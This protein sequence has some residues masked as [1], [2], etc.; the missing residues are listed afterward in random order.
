M[1]TIHEMIGLRTERSPET[2]ANSFGA[3][4]L[5]CGSNKECFAMSVSHD[6]TLPTTSPLLIDEPPLQVQPRLAVAIGLNEAIFLQQVHYWLQKNVGKMH[7]GRRWIYNTLSQWQEQLPFWSVPT[8]KRIIAS[9]REQG[10]LLTR[11]DLN[12]ANMD[13]T[14][15][16]S[17][18]Y[19]VLNQWT[20]SSHHGINLIPS[21]DQFDP[22]HEINLIPSNQ[23]NTQENTQEKRTPPPPNEISANRRRALE[24]SERDRQRQVHRRRR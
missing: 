12:R 1:Q 11:A 8:I 19:G 13:R 20:N 22:M 3:H 5:R 7:E 24:Q 14:H 2:D 15:W 21:S 4:P 6:A 10:V 9:L 17:I 18:D 23:E 16:Y